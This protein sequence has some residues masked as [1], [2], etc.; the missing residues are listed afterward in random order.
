MKYLGVF[1]LFFTL[2]FTSCSKDEDQEQALVDQ[3]LIEGYLSENNLSA[4]RHESGLYYIIEESGSGGNPSSNA[5]VE[6]RYKGYF[7]DG[8]VF[9]QTQGTNSITFNLQNLIPGWQI[10][11]PLLEKGGSGT[12]LLPSELGYGPFPPPGI[13]ANAVLIFDIDLV[14]F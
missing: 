1:L 10:G 14:D 7:L 13:P 11:I 12:F 8:T 2:V 6:V 3:Q 4:T 5:N 9:D